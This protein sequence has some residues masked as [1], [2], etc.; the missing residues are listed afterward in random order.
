MHHPQVVPEGSSPWYLET[1][2]CERLGR[3]RT[4][5]LGHFST[6]PR[7]APD[8]SR[9]SKHGCREEAETR[10]K[11]PSLRTP[12]AGPSLLPGPGQSK[13]LPVSPCP[14]R[15]SGNL[16]SNLGQG[17][18]AASEPPVSQPG[19]YPLR[20]GNGLQPSLQQTQLLSASF[21]PKQT[22]SPG[23][24]LRALPTRA[25]PDFCAG[26]PRRGRGPWVDRK[27]GTRWGSCSS[28]SVP[29]APFTP[30]SLFPSGPDPPGHRWAP[31]CRVEPAA[32]RPRCGP[33]FN[34]SLAAVLPLIPAHSSH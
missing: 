28:G 13:R 21:P 30:K 12:E 14:A 29:S 24:V 3:R 34:W 1:G 32:L 11:R 19:R 25:G 2:H 33:G 27:C 26:T 4:A 20:P 22:A 6:V 7:A 17:G 8:P 18:A 16:A 9:G 10:K 31:F 23:G 5:C 15:V